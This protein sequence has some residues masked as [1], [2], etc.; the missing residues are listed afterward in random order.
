[1]RARYDCSKTSVEICDVLVH[2]GTSEMYQEL[3]WCFRVST[4][5]CRS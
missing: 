5:I 2:G 3:H 1:M 4:N